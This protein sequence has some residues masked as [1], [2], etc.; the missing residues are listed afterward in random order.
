MWENVKK[1]FSGA[2]DILISPFRA[3]FVYIKERINGIIEQI[4]VLIR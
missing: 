3:A 2:F 1:I 4:N